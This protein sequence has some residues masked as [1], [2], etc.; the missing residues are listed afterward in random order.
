MPRS[1][2]I[3]LIA[4]LGWAA[5][6]VVAV[7]LT[8]NVPLRLALALPLLM[9]F[10]GHSLL[11]AL[12]WTAVSATE[13]VI[14]A[15]G[16]SIA[17]ALAAGFLLNRVGMLV[18]LGWALSLLTVVAVSL[19]VALRRKPTD[20]PFPGISKLSGFRM[21]HIAMIALAIAVIGGAYRQAASDAAQ[22][23]QFSYVNFWIVADEKAPGR[24]VVGIESAELDSQVFDIEVMS[25]SQ[26]VAAWRGVA[27]DPG[28]KW[29]RDLSLSVDPERLQKIYARLYRHGDGKLYRQVSAIIPPT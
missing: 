6:T 2:D 17:V 19:A 26:F 12:G 23:R 10:S 28:A 7:S 18:P 8:G 9:L 5:G 22:Q 14:C 11:R 4:I 25:S 21:R 3:D 15:I 29:T 13:H 16:L 1:R 20:T 24:L 27:V